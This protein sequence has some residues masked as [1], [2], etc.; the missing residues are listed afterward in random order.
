M[1]VVELMPSKK[2]PRAPV[3][4]IAK[5][6]T[7]MRI[8]EDAKEQIRQAAEGFIRNLAK[9]SSSHDFFR[10]KTIQSKDV[11]HILDDKRYKRLVPRSHEP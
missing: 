6:E 11:E 2:L 9:E 5:D 1:A 8:S 4:R 7:G 3:T 10:G